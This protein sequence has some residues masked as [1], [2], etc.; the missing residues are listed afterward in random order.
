MVSYNKIIGL[1]LLMLN[2]GRKAGIAHEIVFDIDKNVIEGLINIEIGKKRSFIRLS[3]IKILEDKITV[4]DDKN[5][6]NWDKSS[7]EEKKIVCGKE[8]ISKKVFDFIGNEL[9]YVY[10]IF[11]DFEIGSLEAFHVSD[12]IVEDLIEGRKIIPVL[13]KIELKEE[14][15]FVGKESVEEFVDVKKGIKQI[16]SINEDFTTKNL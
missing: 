16:F 9:G 10:D 12:G 8:L 7:S 15:L 14:G 11:M 3:D 4:K 6:K 13:G 5:M 2:E 1:P